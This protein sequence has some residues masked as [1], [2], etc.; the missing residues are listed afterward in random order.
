[1]RLM[2]RTVK[3]FRAWSHRFFLIATVF[4]FA[5]ALLLSFAGDGWQSRSPR[6]IYAP[7]D[8]GQVGKDLGKVKKDLLKVDVGI[9]VNRIHDVNRAAGTFAAEG[10]LWMGWDEPLDGD[11]YSPGRID[12]AG[13][14][15]DFGVTILEFKNA[16]PSETK[17]VN[18]GPPT[19]E[20]G[21]RLWQGTR[22]STTFLMAEQNFSKF[23]FEEVV[24]PIEIGTDRFVFSILE[25]RP[26]MKDSLI[27]DR[28]E[29][30]GFRFLGL[31]AISSELTITTHFGHALPKDGIRGPGWV[32][33]SAGDYPSYPHLEW[34][35]RFGRLPST[36]SVKLFV[37]V[38]AAMV[39]LMFSL[40]L[41]VNVPTPKISIPASILLV[42]AVLQDRSHQLLPPNISYLTYMDKIYLFAY[43][44]TTSAL[45]SSLYCL[46]SYYF[47]VNSQNAKKAIF[48]RAQQRLLV[49][50]MC[51]S[52]SIVPFLLWIV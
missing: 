7:V 42:L 31:E 43:I 34:L 50:L 39:V 12:S 6:E 23:P 47:D 48:L 30:L 38:A 16:V 26:N 24:L 45:V 44:L 49:S 5:L 22:F 46:N 27:S 8:S 29:L 41:S 21:G 25:Y 11:W 37:P 36:L 33:L 3:A 4:G 18:L 40:L 52:M 32:G 17:R 19:K 51:I 14:G 15:E 35:M 20:P 2:L 13:L 10:W 9:Y 28:L 1:M